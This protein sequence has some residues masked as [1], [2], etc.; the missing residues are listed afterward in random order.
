MAYFNSGQRAGGPAN[1]LLVRATATLE[2]GFLLIFFLD[3]L[4]DGRC[5]GYLTS[6]YPLHEFISV[7]RVKATIDCNEL[8]T[9][10]RMKRSWP[11]LRC[12]LCFRLEELRKHQWGATLCSESPIEVRRMVKGKFFPTVP[13]VFCA[14]YSPLASSTLVVSVAEEASHFTSYHRLQKCVV[15]FRTTNPP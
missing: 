14:V 10:H 7:D 2:Q 3:T 5:V 6:L 13:S 8:R 11:I 15:E 1:R 12:S 4:V 9:R